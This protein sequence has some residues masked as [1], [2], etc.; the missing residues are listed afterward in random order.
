MRGT[1]TIPFTKA[2]NIIAT[3]LG[4]VLHLYLCLCSRAH[5]IHTCT[6]VHVRV[7]VHVYQPAYSPRILL[8]GHYKLTF[9]AALLIRGLGLAR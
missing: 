6:R 2:Y 9:M 4:G 8:C 5:S 3:M 7:L 1:C